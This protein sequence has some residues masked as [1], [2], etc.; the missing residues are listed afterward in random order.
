M[1]FRRVMSDAACWPCSS[2]EHAS[3]GDAAKPRQKERSLHPRGSLALTI[4]RMRVRS[5]LLASCII[6]LA[7]AGNNGDDDD[8]GMK[9]KK[10]DDDIHP[11]DRQ[12]DVPSL[13]PVMMSD[14]PSIIPT[15]TEDMTGEVPSMLPTLPE[16]M[17][18][19]PKPVPIKG[20]KKKKSPSSMDKLK[21]KKGMKKGDD[22][23]NSRR[24]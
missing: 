8:D 3:P 14:V 1:T 23:D 5:Y 19:V 2:K 22:D 4:N 20:M 12:S 24:L 13:A 15:I 7:I 16:D 10:P 17:M 6:G 21:K 11:D 18:P 9:G